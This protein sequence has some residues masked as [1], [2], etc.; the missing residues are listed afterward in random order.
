MMYTFLLVLT[1]MLSAFSITGNAVTAMEVNAPQVANQN[2]IPVEGGNLKSKVDSAIRLGRANARGGRFWVGYQF[3]PK[4][5]VMIGRNISKGEN[6]AAKE[7]EPQNVG[8]FILYEANSDAIAKLEL[9]NLDQQNDFNGAP[10]YWLGRATN[11][12]SLSLL[13]QILNEQPEGKIGEQA[14]AGIALHNDS[15]V[16]QILEGVAMQSKSEQQR[17]SAIFWLGQ[18]EGETGFLSSLLGNE[19][20]SQEIRKQ[21]AFAI[22]VSK[23]PSALTV[24]QN[25]YSQVKPV[26]VKKQII[27]AHFVN[28]NSDAAVD[29][30]IRVASTDTE[31]ETRKQAIFWL[32]QKAGQRATEVLNNTI[33]QN[34]ADTEVQKEAVF[35]VSRRKKEEAVPMLIKIA[36]THPKA[37]V[38]KQALFWLG[39]IDDERALEVFKEILSK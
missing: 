6:L 3:E 1:V 14:V 10:V 7:K 13:Q 2:F 11:N 15:R 24:L 32:G 16:G 21:A 34:D 9:K 36:K 28:H 37:E 17:K 35:A 39:Q 19:Q 31:R 25:L 8:I 33:E 38:R 27:F 29:F 23:D 20:E 22:G 18:T 4:P 30:L 12:E 26:E 5:G